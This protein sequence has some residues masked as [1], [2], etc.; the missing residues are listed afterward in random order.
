M[1]PRTAN[2]LIWRRE[3]DLPS[4]GF[5]DAVGAETDGLAAGRQLLRERW[6]AVI[7]VIAL[8]VDSV[9]APIVEFPD[10]SAQSVPGCHNARCPITS[11]PGAGNA[12]IGRTERGLCQLVDGS[13]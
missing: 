10:D 12:L 4:T 7:A 6:G 11:R 1:V 13:Q 5:S 2:A 9:E 3:C 8:V